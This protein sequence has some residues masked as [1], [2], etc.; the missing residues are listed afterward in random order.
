MANQQNYRENLMETTQFLEKMKIACSNVSGILKDK[1]EKENVLSLVFDRWKKEELDQAISNT[2]YEKQK[3][4]GVYPINREELA[5]LARFSFN[6]DNYNE[7]M[8][9]II[10]H[11]LAAQKIYERAN[12]LNTL[13]TRRIQS[14]LKEAEPISRKKL[15]WLFTSSKTKQQAALAIE[16]LEDLETNEDY[17]HLV[18]ELIYNYQHISSFDTDEM[19]SKHAGG[20]CNAINNNIKSR[21]YPEKDPIQPSFQEADYLLSSFVSLNQAMENIL[22]KISFIKKEIATAANLCLNEKMLE[23]LRILDVEEI[24]RDKKGIR[25][26]AL[27]NEGYD[28]IEKIYLADVLAISD[29]KGISNDGAHLIKEEAE[30]IANETRRN[31]RLR[32]NSDDRNKNSELLLKTLLPYLAQK[33]YIDDFER[34]YQEAYEAGHK[35]SRYCIENA[36]PIGWIK[37]DANGKE[38]IGKYLDD[39]KEMDPISVSRDLEKYQTR[40][41]ITAFD[42]GSEFL[43]DFFTRYTADIYAVLDEIIPGLFGDENSVY[44]LSEELAQK[45]RDEAVFPNG[46]LVTLRRYQEWGVKYILH[47]KKVLL[48]DEMGL[49]KTIQ[50]LAAMVSL[51]NT[52]ANHFMVV[53]PASVIINWCREIREKSLLQAIRVHGN[54]RKQAFAYWLEKGGVAVTTYETTAFLNLPEDF[55]YDMLVVDEAHYVKNPKALRTQNVLKLSEQTDRVLYMTGTALENNVEEMIQLISQLNSEV[56]K[57]VENIKYLSTAESFREKISSVYYRRK[58]EDVLQELPELI[59]SREWTILNEEEKKIYNSDVLDKN[60][61]NIRKVSWRMDDIDQS[62]KFERLK[63]LIEDAKEDGRKI[64]IFS[65]YLEV[66]SKIQEKLAMIAYGPINGSVLPAK[67]QE[68]IDEFEAAPAGSVLLAQIQAGGTGLNIQSAS[69]VILC[70]PQLKPSTENQA[71]S[72]CYRMGQSRNVLVYRL[73]CDDTIDE[74]MMELLAEKQKVFDAF[75]DKSSAAMENMEIDDQSFGDLIEKEIER[76]KA[77]ENK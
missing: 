10:C 8:V 20:L 15:G 60:Q 55:K 26:S 25:V 37:S 65:F 24:N 42:G 6:K 16:E 29:I 74:R 58:R 73:L 46:L 70:E 50:A 36:N 2:S 32:I 64:I 11:L 71:I 34:F 62:S 33:P 3:Q 44:G 31:T 61:A 18:N 56:A 35:K 21:L 49:G 43:W 77:E 53:C 67:R 30:K 23:T 66:I 41:V 59:E 76:I 54:N 7:E 38:Q 40:Q 5:K 51:K 1:K 68:I 17:L 69:V 22:D 39:L 28:T 12:S 13:Y 52:G 27:R 19:I 4:M 47:Q 57:S 45:V 14:L 48:G 72:R 75:A 63:E 9:E